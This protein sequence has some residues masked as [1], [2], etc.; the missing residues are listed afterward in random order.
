MLVGLLF[1]AFWLSD[2][3][4]LNFSLNEN[5]ITTLIAIGIFFGPI[6]V[7]VLW[8]LL[9]GDLGE[10]GGPLVAGAGGWA[11]L[12]VI[13]C[14]HS[15]TSPK[16]TVTHYYCPYCNAELFPTIGE[17]TTCMNCYKQ[18]HVPRRT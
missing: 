3:I 6:S 7:L 14:L 2:R 10:Y 17:T 18:I 8:G 9:G 11:A 13:G 5:I 15:L 12:F 16:I 4:Q 1:L